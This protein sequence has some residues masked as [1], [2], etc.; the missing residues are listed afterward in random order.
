MHAVDGSQPTAEEKGD[1][2]TL[3]LSEIHLLYFCTA[4]TELGKYRAN[5]E[6]RSLI[7]PDE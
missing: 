5:E 3:S 7:S 6:F 2:I 1:N 4:S